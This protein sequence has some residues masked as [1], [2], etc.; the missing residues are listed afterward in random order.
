M[1]SPLLAFIEENP[2]VFELI[3]LR[4][5]QLQGL[6]LSREEARVLLARGNAL[7]VHIARFFRERIA[8]GAMTRPD[9]KALASLPSYLDL[10][11]PDV[12]A[13][14]PAGSIENTASTTAYLV[15]LREWVRDAI[16]DQADPTTALPLD[17][18]RP[19]VD[20]L[21]INEMAV[22]RQESRLEI[23]N[24]VLEAQISKKLG[25]SDVKAYLRTCR[26]HNGLP[27]DHDWESITHVAGKAVKDGVLGDVVRRVDLD[28]PYFKN[29][30]AR[31]QRADA[32]QQLSSGIGPLQLSL[33][34][35]SP[36]FPLNA[37]QAK[38][39]LSRVNPRTRLIDPTPQVSVENFYR[40]NFGQEAVELASLRWLRIFSQATRL[41]PRGVDALLGHG[42]FTP[43][44]SANAPTFGHPDDPKT[45][46][47][48]GA[49]YIHGG[50]APA[51]DLIRDAIGKQF[52]LY[53]V[54]ESGSGLLAH[55][56]DRINRKCRLDRMLKLPSHQVDQLLIAAM[57]AEGRATGEKLTWITTNTLRCLGVFKELNTRY[58][59]EAEEF[60]ALVDVLSV[61]GQDGQP[62][63]FDRVYNVQALYD[64]PLR[65]DDVE[66]AITPRDKAEQ[67]TVHQIC[68][69]LDI[70]F[71]TYRFLA[72]VIARA[73]GF[74]THLSRS[75]KVFTSFWRLVRLARMFKLSP[76]EATAL[77]QTLSDGEGLVS[78]LAGE[79]IVLS[80]GLEDGA[81]ALSTIRGLMECA[82]WSKDYDL[83]AFWLVQNVNPVYVP[84]VWTQGQEQFL[85][86]L[87]NQVLPVL[88]DQATLLEEGA[89]LR[90]KNQALIDWLQR[91]ENLV[92][93]NGLVVGRYDETEQ[94]YLD[95][96]DAAI[97]AVVDDVTENDEALRER[98]RGI[99]RSILLRCRDEQR[100][101]VEEG[102]AVYLKLDSLLAAQVMR[103]SKGHT[104]DFLHKAMSLI[105]VK[106]PLAA[107]QTDAD[108]F[109]T[110]LA[111][112]ERR[113][114]I[115]DKLG[116]SPQMLGTLLTGEQYLWFSLRD[117]F[118]IS[119][120][121]VYYLTFYSR[122]ISRTGQPEEK[123]LDYLRQVNQLPDDMSEDGLRLAR[124][125]AADKL[126]TYFGCGIKHVL[127]CVEHISL[128]TAD[129]PSP[130]WP[131][132][133]NL[134][135]FDL[136]LH[137][138]E[139][140]SNGMDATAA[141]SMG[142]LYPLD[143]E[144]NYASAARNALESLARFV[145]LTTVPDSAE[146]GQSVSTRCV[147][148]NPRLIANLTQEVA[149]FECTLLDF[150]EQPLKGV[151]IN[152][153]TDIGAILTPSTRTDEH[154]RAW[155]LLQAGGRVGT[156]HVS[157]S[158]PLY[159]PVYAPS[160]VIDC[161]EATLYFGIPFMSPLPEHPILAGYQAEQEV[162]ARMLDR[163]G[164][165][166]ALR[167][168]EWF[169]TNGEIRPSETFTD[170]DGY[171]RVWV[172]SLSPGKAEIAVADERGAQVW[173][174]GAIEFADKPRIIDQPFAVSVAVTGQ[175]L[176]VR[177]RVVGLDGAP[178]AD[179]TVTWWTS[180]DSAKIPK[181]SDENGHS[182]FS[183]AA[184]ALGDLTFFAQLDTD[185]VVELTVW[186]AKDA[187]I[188]N[189]STDKHFPIVGGR[190]T[191]LW[192]DVKELNDPQA[193][194]LANYPV[195]WELTS[196][197]SSGTVQQTPISTDAQGRS[198]FAFEPLTEGSY[199]LTAALT[200]HAG[201]TRTFTLTV[202]E[203]FEWQ[204]TLVT[205]PGEADE[206]RDPI[207]PR[208]DKLNL[209]RN[210]KYRLEFLPAKPEPLAGSAGA[211]GWS[212]EYTTTALQMLFSP[213]LAT[214]TDFESGQPWTVNI[215]IGDV[216]N[217]N[218]QLHLHCDLLSEVLVLEGSLNKRP[219]VL[220][221]PGKPRHRII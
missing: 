69:A 214:R 3:K 67:Q 14:A 64:E 179:Q 32:A 101:V 105:G 100:T 75:L 143:S 70:N 35:E 141:F 20:M 218:F 173:F 24:S 153:V 16:V 92:D 149:E 188:Q 192:V 79:P 197:S 124:D 28:Y 209:L 30:G 48:S 49:I 170:K 113:G 142:T 138:L 29:P 169:T 167:K 39:P 164:N 203:A 215:G 165:P 126:A 117:R 8:R 23:L 51:I 90:D 150:Y 211:L 204:V 189:A 102:I 154:G 187:V 27:Y 123:V 42:P 18:R 89:P 158:L 195:Q 112:L 15:A 168:V 73:F 128:Q 91:L 181:P 57:R 45:G 176:T 148:D 10:F 134:N 26:F 74:T 151:Y 80:N 180:A 201:Q 202:L 95:R 133:S 177:C 137:T 208:K 183:V 130:T 129:D 220:R 108:P 171:T 152:W 147:V 34:L 33:L 96:A 66:F 63:Q 174:N 94:Q 185:P 206:A 146:V 145:S 104:Y 6:G 21:V 217:G 72:I 156:A 136:L 114:R 62:S 116:L 118:E 61:Y 76:I 160:V 162:S 52:Q 111:E 172:S 1:N 12:Y 55:R 127:E 83:P 115:A 191:L 93:E 47:D 97:R 54:G 53:H 155:A 98:V 2:S 122:M 161:D 65:I 60:A 221:E 4:P 207:N 87:R 157:F 178:V 36:Y 59:C 119:I 56:M 85:R 82:I 11:N 216:R 184:P 190:P 77:L 78:R 200:H 88:L 212:S 106:S 19:D 199:L 210:G 193:K 132:L 163:Y 135:H 44:L 219:P 71:E 182:D 175:P 25:I 9:E 50:E 13:S 159:E 125:A 107:L 31:G 38:A 58:G 7:A 86:Q 103:W 198:V 84:T 43:A 40:Q 110:M 109:L 144:S 196:Q 68:N 120:Q 37:Q 166:G 22:S 46:V 186:V 205:N 213:P 194:P 41:D 131:I 139:L 5:A 99:I 17:L 121:T 140:A 81:D